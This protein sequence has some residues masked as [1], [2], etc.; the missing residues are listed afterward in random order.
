MKTIRSLLVPFLY[1]LA[2][3]ALSFILPAC[4]LETVPDAPKE[5]I[6]TPS[7]FVLEGLA[8][9]VVADCPFPVTV[10]ALDDLG[11]RLTPYSG[12]LSISPTNPMAV[13]DVYISALFEGIAVGVLTFSPLPG[14]LPL[15]TEL[16]ISSG[17]CISTTPSY[18]IEE[19]QLVSFDV[20]APSAVASGNAFPLHLRALN[21][22]GGV[23][24]SFS[25]SVALSCTNP[26]V[27]ISPQTTPAFSNGQVTI[28]VTLTGD[29]DTRIGAQNL[30]I[31]G[32]SDTIAVGPWTHGVQIV[33]W[34]GRVGYDSSIIAAG[35]SIL[36]SYYDQTNQD[37]KVAR[38]ADGGSS[39]SLA[40]VDTAGDVGNYSSICAAGGSHYISYFDDSNDDLKLAKSTDGGSSWSITTVD[41]T[42]G[43]DVGFDSSIVAE[44]DSIYIAYRDWTNGDLRF[45]VSDDQGESWA[46][47]TV[48]AEASVVG[49]NIGL[50]VHGTNIYI[51]YH[52]WHSEAYDDWMRFARSA[53]GG[54]SWTIQVVEDEDAL[55]FHN[56]LAIDG[57]DVYM[58]YNTFNNAIKVAKGINH[59]E[60]WWYQTIDNNNGEYPDMTIQNHEI[61]LSY[62]RHTSE[63]YKQLKYASSL[64]GG[65]SWSIVHIYTNA[66]DTSLAVDGTQICISFC[67]WSSGDLML[68]KSIDGGST[69]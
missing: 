4:K 34:E 17:G 19:P 68:A 8:A 26:G 14:A 22:L 36:I 38:S 6:P 15:T 65:L 53:D 46:L 50:A 13:T 52:C 60:S 25:D 18:T 9:K 44:A 16:T 48:D 39:W 3:L 62:V 58:S 27:G 67:D 31:T 24:R 59:G 42:P 7:S 30:G 43:M 28:Y 5:T 29:G 20:T 23:F 41:D 11:E 40:V 55:G 10:E 47:Q 1:I 45:A 51:T 49:G 2:I 12:S 61:C 56:A 69:W 37:L 35:D 32:E 66:I 54:D 33:D 63:G 64:D 57:T 21:Q